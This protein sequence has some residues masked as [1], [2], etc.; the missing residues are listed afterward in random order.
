MAW[1]PELSKKDIRE[2]SFK[3][4][5]LGKSSKGK[6]DPAT[7]Q[8][9]END[10]NMLFKNVNEYSTSEPLAFSISALKRIGILNN[11]LSIVAMKAIGQV[12][13]FQIEGNNNSTIM[14]Q[15][16]VNLKT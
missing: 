10:F 8:K 13:K 15:S 14:L 16:M 12:S 11:K 1:E 5:D 2:L 7:K 4:L 6:L 3:L 9:I